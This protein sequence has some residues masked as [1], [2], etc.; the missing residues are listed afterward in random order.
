MYREISFNS[1]LS[2]SISF[3][4]TDNNSNTSLPSIPSMTPSGNNFNHNSSYSISNQLSSSLN[5][6]NSNNNNNSNNSCCYVSPNKKRSRPISYSEEYDLNSNSNYLPPITT[7]TNSI[8]SVNT[9]NTKNSNLLFSSQDS[10][11]NNLDNSTY[12]EESEI[13]TNLHLNKQFHEPLPVQN[14]HNRA[15]NQ[16]NDNQN[17]PNKLQKTIDTPNVIQSVLNHFLP[18]PALKI[19]KTT[20]WL[21]SNEEKPRF[22]WDF[23]DI[24]DLGRGAHSSVYVARHRLDGSLYAIKKLNS[25]ID[26]K[27]PTFNDV[28]EVC[29]NVALKGCPN[30]VQYFGC[31]IEDSHLWLQL[32]LCLR[33]NLD[34]FVI[35]DSIPIPSLSRPNSSSMSFPSINDN[36]NHDNDDNLSDVVDDDKNQEINDQEKCGKNEFKTT[37][38]KYQQQQQVNNQKFLLSEKSFWKIL[39]SISKAL[40]FIHSKCK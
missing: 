11:M 25:Y 8:N 34:I 20:I 31:W 23:V 17:N 9:T 6:S 12:H 14:F 24:Q 38:Q 3:T 22:R 13:K 27:Q 10:V 28:K 16:Y 35:S 1:E 7:I 33:V 15:Y 37:P 39:Y 26:D 36:D 32:E 30:L 19:S 2:Q 40:E 18:Q 4:P 21:N 5:L 29:A